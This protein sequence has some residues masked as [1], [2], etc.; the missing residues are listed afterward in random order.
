[1]SVADTV[2]VMLLFATVF[3]AV[4]VFIYILDTLK[5][6]MPD[7]AEILDKG[8]NA[9]KTFIKSVVYVSLL[10]C[11]AGIL[12]AAFSP[13]HPVLLPFSI[14]LLAVSLFMCNLVVML[15][16]NIIQA[17]EIHKNILDQF[18]TEVYI[19]R[20]FNNVLCITG[21]IIMIIQYARR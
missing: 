7:Q 18:A 1:M 3:I 4:P 21:F 14:L 16:D 20:N 9:E 19:F 8:I 6:G 2:F 17:S 10:T 5:V 15:V 12:L 11:V 13:S